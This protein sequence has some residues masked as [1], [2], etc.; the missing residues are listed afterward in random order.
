M[1]KLN[2]RK[3]LVN[4]LIDELGI[5]GRNPKL[6]YVV[7]KIL[8]EP[9]QEYTCTECEERDGSPFV[10]ADDIAE[11]ICS[12]IASEI[13]WSFGSDIRSIIEDNT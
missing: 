1:Y 7:D 8:N 6:D 2:E 10:D 3:D 4:F 5:D 11:R 13:S 12:H 9:V